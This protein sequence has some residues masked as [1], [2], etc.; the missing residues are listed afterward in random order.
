[1]FS[2]TVSNRKSICVGGLA[3]QLAIPMSAQAV[4]CGLE[5]VLTYVGKTTY[6]F[7]D[8][9]ISTQ[10]KG[11][12]ESLYGLL[13]FPTSYPT[14]P[15]TEIG[16]DILTPGLSTYMPTFAARRALGPVQPTVKTPGYMTAADYYAWSSLQSAI[17]ATKVQGAKTFACTGTLTE[18]L[19][20]ISGFFANISQ[21]TNGASPTNAPNTSGVAWGM[22]K[23]AEDSS[24]GECP[25][26]TEGKTTLLVEGKLLK[27][28]NLVD[29]INPKTNTKLWMCGFRDPTAAVTFDAALPWDQKNPPVYVESN[30]ASKTQTGSRAPQYGIY[31][32]RGPKQL[33]HWYNY[34]WAGNLRDP[35]APNSL[36]DDPNQVITN[37]TIGWETA[38]AYQTQRYQEPGTTF[39]KP[40]MQD[41]QIPA[42]WLA[43][44]KTYPQ[45]DARGEWGFGQTINVINGGVE[46]TSDTNYQVLN[47]INNYIEFMIRLGVDVRELTVGQADG[48]VATFTKDELESNIYDRDLKYPWAGGTERAWVTAPMP[49]SYYGTYPPGPPGPY[50]LKYYDKDKA[51][52]IDERLDCRGY[53]T[54]N[55]EQ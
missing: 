16:P 25:A 10:T 35:Q 37:A 47:R 29:A 27:D 23:Y 45:P 38:L 54:Y 39:T 9:V 49:T 33:T 55:K 30:D 13:F 4:P 7:L 24:F 15:K 21:E 26:S 2:I 11:V 22:T 8:P 14:R 53:L 42:R 41:A 36:V 20:D 50:R 5:E 12:A 19:T 31:Y 34:A 44:K 3:L 51:T 1:M 52:L 6:G 40:S 46:C 18:R 17:N 28:G 32:G 43:F 48:S